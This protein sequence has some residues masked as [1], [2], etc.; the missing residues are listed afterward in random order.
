MRTEAIRTWSRIHTTLFQLTRGRIGRHARGMDYLLLTTTG[1]RSG[2]KHTVPLLYL[3]DGSN[4]VAIASF[5][6]K[7]RHPDWFHNLTRDPNVTVQV[8]GDRLAAM[9]RV[10]DA[11]ERARL[12]PQAVA[13]WPDYEAYQRRTE[14]LIPV[15]ILERTPPL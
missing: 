12:W 2:K 6:G 8:G 3:R 15:V 1:R 13:V 11:E 14:R 7:P 4:L 5:G 9:A 10:A